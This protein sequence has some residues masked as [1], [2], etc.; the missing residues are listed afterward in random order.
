LFGK[1]VI[2]IFQ[3]NIF[4]KILIFWQIIL[5]FWLFGKLIFIVKSQPFHAYFK[6][7]I[8]LAK[9]FNKTKS[10]LQGNQDALNNFSIFL[11]ENFSKSNGY[12]NC[13]LNYYFLTNP[14][15]SS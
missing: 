8:F 1:N 7:F 14:K 9:F 3:D 15:Y 6:I 4:L 13:N 5:H 10:H 11:K 2:L 12:L